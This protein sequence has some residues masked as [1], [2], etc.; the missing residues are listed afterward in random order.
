MQIL[1]G[2][3]EFQAESLGIIFVN[4]SERP[5]YLFCCQR[6]FY[7]AERSK[8]KGKNPKKKFKRMVSEVSEDSTVGILTQGRLKLFCTFVS[9]FTDSNWLIAQYVYLLPV[10]Q[11]SKVV[12]IEW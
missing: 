1:I 8:P 4:P 6:H 5:Q 10:E 12:F 9:Y 7:S 3:S 2:S 11:L